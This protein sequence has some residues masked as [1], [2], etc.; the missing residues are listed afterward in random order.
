MAGKRSFISKPYSL[1]EV[2]QRIKQVLL[3]NA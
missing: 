2:D 1:A 3:R